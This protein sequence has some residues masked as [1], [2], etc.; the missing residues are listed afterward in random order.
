MAT[1]RVSAGYHHGDLRNALIKTCLSLLAESGLDAL[2]LRE[3]ARRAGVSHTACYRHFLDREAL[4]AAVA[5]EGFALLQQ[6]LATASAGAPDALTA[7]KRALD[8]YLNFGYE[9]RPYLQLMFGIDMSARQPALKSVA[10]DAF[11]ALV[12]L[13]SAAVP[14]GQPSD[15]RSLALALWAEVHGLLVLSSALQLQDI[16]PGH[17]SREAA[18]QALNVLLDRVLPSVHGGRIEGSS[19]FGQ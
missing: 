12:Q 7:L 19:V 4:L 17:Q 14:T 11:N 6:E 18:R 5:A 16:A 3:V 15:S 9:Q 13:V 10:T 2:S 1:L 8:A